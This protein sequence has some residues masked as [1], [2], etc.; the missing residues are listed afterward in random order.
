MLV[1][2]V[3]FLY[4]VLFP[5][6]RLL[7]QSH[8]LPV[9]SSCSW[10]G[11]RELI[12]YFFEGMRSKPENTNG[13]D[14]DLKDIQEYTV[15][16]EPWWCNIGYSS[17]PSAMTGGNTSN[18]TSSEG[19]NGSESNDDQS[20]SSG[21]LNEEDADANKDSQA[22]ASSQLGAANYFVAENA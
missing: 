20:L 8:L 9:H 12:N 10:A 7:C 14:A 2:S 11:N 18:L 13:L 15:N 6:A 19:H 22:T 21:R 3:S 5:L 1:F 16:S 4:Q 17:I